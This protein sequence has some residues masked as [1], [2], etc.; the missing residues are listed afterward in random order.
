MF[1]ALKITNILNQ[2]GGDWKS[3]SCHENIIFL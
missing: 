1:F 3:E 2:V